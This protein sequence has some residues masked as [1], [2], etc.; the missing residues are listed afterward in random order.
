[1]GKASFNKQQRREQH[2]TDCFQCEAVAVSQVAFDE[3]L[4]KRGVRLEAEP[5]CTIALECSECGAPRVNAYHGL[6]DEMKRELSNLMLMVNR[7]LGLRRS[8]SDEVQRLYDDFSAR[9]LERCVLLYGV[10]WLEAA[11][12]AYARMDQ[13]FAEHAEEFAMMMMQPPL[14]RQRRQEMRED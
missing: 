9:Y 3:A 7:D 2:A 13:F 1:M 6:D 12:A 5:G 11:Q 8:F 14:T 4:A 10:S